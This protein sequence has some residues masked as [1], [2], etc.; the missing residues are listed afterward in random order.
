MAKLPWLL[1]FLLK[2][3]DVHLVDLGADILSDLGVRQKGRVTP[4]GR[5]R[6]GQRPTQQPRQ[7]FT[8]KLDIKQDLFQPLKQIQEPRLTPRPSGDPFF[9]IVGGGVPPVVTGLLLPPLVFPTFRGG[10]KRQKGRRPRER[11]APS[12]TGQVLFDLGD[13]TGDPLKL[14]GRGGRSP[15]D[16]RFVPRA[17]KRKSK[18]KK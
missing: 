14:S 15:F 17:P 6:T 13:I 12:L 3:L 9:D 16:I 18:K 7:D 2:T 10:R 4:R 5:G 11:I 1:C 8:P